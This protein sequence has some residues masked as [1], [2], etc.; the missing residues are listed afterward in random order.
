MRGKKPEPDE[1]S[2][3]QIAEMLS[4]GEQIKAL[5]EL[6]IATAKKLQTEEALSHDPG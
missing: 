1:T 3:K 6:V 4:L 5:S 2:Q